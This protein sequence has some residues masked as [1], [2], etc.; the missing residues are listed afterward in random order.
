[1][2]VSLMCNEPDWAA[3]VKLWAHTA[4]DKRTYFFAIT[5]RDKIIDGLVAPGGE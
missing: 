2:K 1:M 5:M 3:I 4:T